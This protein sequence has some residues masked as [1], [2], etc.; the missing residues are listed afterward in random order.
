MTS[1]SI[2]CIFTYPP[3]GDGGDDI[4]GF[5]AGVPPDPGTQPDGE[6]LHPDSRPTWPPRNGRVRARRSDTPRR[7]IVARMETVMKPVLSTSAAARR[8]GGA[9]YPQNFPGDHRRCIPPR[10]S[11]V[12]ATTSAIP[13]KVT[14]PFRKAC[15]GHFVRRV[16]DR[17]GGASRPGRRSRPGGKGG[18]RCPRPPARRRAATWQP[19]RSSGALGSGQ[20]RGQVSACRIGNSMVGTPIC[21]IT[22]PST[23]ST[24]ECTME[25]GM[26]NYVDTVVGELP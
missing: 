8:P 4:L 12:P 16:E 26:H 15:N 7:T 1:S 19:G 5:A 9:V 24:K 18:K 6:P 22:E 11:R 25:D 21:E 13:G 17:G 20:R 14:L 3:E 23:N 2:P 10:A